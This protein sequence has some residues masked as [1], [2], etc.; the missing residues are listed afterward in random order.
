MAIVGTTI[1]DAVIAKISEEYPNTPIYD[2][3][4]KQGAER[5][6]FFISSI[7]TSKIKDMN[8]MYNELH[9]IKV[10]YFDKIDNNTTKFSNLNNIGNILMDIL[11]EIDVG[12]GGSNTSTYLVRG[13]QMSWKN[14][15]E[16]LNFFISYPIRIFRPKIDEP[17]QT[18][19]TIGESIKD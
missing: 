10:Q 19:L 6:Y 17:K 15:E 5:P 7:D 12:I 2:E 16:V 13:I 3:T 1:V 9:Q 14:I 4:M 8:Q 18:N 11:E